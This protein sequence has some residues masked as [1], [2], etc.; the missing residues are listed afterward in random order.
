MTASAMILGSKPPREIGDVR[1]TTID[2]YHL[3]WRELQVS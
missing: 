3:G 2:G 1:L